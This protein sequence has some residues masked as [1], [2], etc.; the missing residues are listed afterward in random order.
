MEKE[1]D[2]NIFMKALTNFF[3][4]KSFVVDKFRDIF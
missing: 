3:D 1:A 4:K 2:W